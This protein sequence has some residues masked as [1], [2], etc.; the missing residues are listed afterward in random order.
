[1]RIAICEDT[2]AEREI[3][4]QMLRQALDDA[5]RDAELCLFETGD[6]MAAAIKRGEAW[7]ICFLDIYLPKASGVELAEAV[8][9]AHD[10]T[11]LVFTTTSTEH[12]ADG[13]RVGAVHYLVKPFS[14]SDVDEA[15][16]RAL[17]LVDDTGRCIELI[18]DRI[19]STVPLAE[20]I[21]LESQNHSTLLHTAGRSLRSYM[22]L[23][24]LAPLLDERF[25]RCHRSYIVNMD[26]IAHATGNDFEMDTGA[27]IPLRREERTALRQAYHR[28][29][30]EKIRGRN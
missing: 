19:P 16:A 26:H 5:R 8:R 27:L 13:F 29:T 15:L 1:M 20:L 25:L 7:D 18:I 22:R 6:D 17:R 21:F 23:D 11:V 2:P 10:Q 4:E 9:A 28:H 3:L 12:M 30:I 24:E 14:Q